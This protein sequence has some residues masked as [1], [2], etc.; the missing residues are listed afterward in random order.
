METF[1]A[2]IIFAIFAAIAVCDSYDP[3][4]EIAKRLE[5]F[6]KTCQKYDDDLT[7]EYSSK[8]IFHYSLSPGASGGSWTRT[9]KRRMMSQVSDHCALPANSAGQLCPDLLDDMT[10]ISCSVLFITLNMLAYHLAHK[11]SL[12]SVGRGVNTEGAHVRS[13]RALCERQGKFF[14]KISSV[15]SF[16]WHTS[17]VW[18]AL[19]QFRRKIY[20]L[21]SAQNEGP[22]VV[23]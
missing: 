2:K 6:R 22:D 4:T 15:F 13:Q 8:T 17:R 12:R 5:I 16:V 19:L 23:S 14:L 3:E 18:T 11:R 10:K 7:Y 21:R 9:R 20:R 1:F